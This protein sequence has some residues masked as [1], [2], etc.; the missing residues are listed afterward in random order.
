MSALHQH[1]QRQQDRSTML[2]GVI[3]AIALLESENWSGGEEYDALLMVAQD[4]A[5]QINVALDVVNLPKGGV[6]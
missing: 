2:R 5:D 3:R 4:L 1:I 6:V